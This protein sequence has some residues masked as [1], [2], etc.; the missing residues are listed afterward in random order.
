LIDRFPESTRITREHL[1]FWK[2]LA[3]TS[4]T[5][6]ATDQ[7]E[8]HFAGEEASEGLRALAENREVDYRAFRADVDAARHAP[9]PPDESGSLTELKKKAE[10]RSCYSCGAQDLPGSFDYCGFCGTRLV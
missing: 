6:R 10:A 1:S 5:K 7:L 2:D 8:S 3:W 9:R 4:M